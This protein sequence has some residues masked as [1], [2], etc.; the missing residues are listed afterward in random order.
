MRKK[1]KDWTLQQKIWR[2][3]L[4]VLIMIFG[5]L[6]LGALLIPNSEIFLKYPWLHQTIFFMV[7]LGIISLIFFILYVVIDLAFSN[8]RLEDV[9]RD[10][11]KKI[12]EFERELTRLKTL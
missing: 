11:E 12:N 3:F 4:S 2:I 8:Q 6:Y 5:C 9:N 7:L 1:F 10:L